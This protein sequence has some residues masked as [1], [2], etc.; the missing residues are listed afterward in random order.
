MLYIKYKTNK[1]Y[2]SNTKKMSNTLKYLIDDIMRSCFNNAKRSIIDNLELEM[3]KTRN[4]ELKELLAAKSDEI[5]NSVIYVRPRVAVN[6]SN[7]RFKVNGTPLYV[8]KLPQNAFIKFK[9]AIANLLAC[10]PDFSDH[11]RIG[12]LQPTARV[13]GAIKILHDRGEMDQQ[14]LDELVDEAKNTKEVE[15]KK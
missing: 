11:P 13:Y 9:T 7:E 3:S 15:D 2:L 4:P 12:D 8:D 5:I 10:K 14:S 6:Y 1:V